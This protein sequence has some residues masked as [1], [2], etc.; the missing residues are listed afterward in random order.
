MTAVQVMKRNN[1]KDF[2]VNAAPLGVSHLMV[3]TRSETAVTLR[4]IRN[5]QGPTLT[6]KG[7]RRIRLWL[8]K[9]GNFGKKRKFY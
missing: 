4:I 9:F 3:L 2:V 6:F 7:E 1:L 5:P 8:I